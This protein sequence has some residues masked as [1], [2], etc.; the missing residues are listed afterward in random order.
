MHNV[1]FFQQIQMT[2][3]YKLLIADNDKLT[4]N[5]TFNSH[6][7]SCSYTVKNIRYQC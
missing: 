2:D 4:N 5:L 3:Y 7:H 6:D 1:Y